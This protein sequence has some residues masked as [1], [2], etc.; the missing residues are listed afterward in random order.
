MTVD[1]LAARVRRLDALARGLAK[2][3]AAVQ[4]DTLTVLLYRER[5]GYRRRSTGPWPALRTR[6]SPRLRAVVSHLPTI[7]DC[8]KIMKK[9]VDG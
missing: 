3:T 6:G 5:R 4:V 2:E 9:Q 7:P 8:Q 1:D